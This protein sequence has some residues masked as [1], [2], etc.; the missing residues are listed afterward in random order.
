M[1]QQVE[2]TVKSASGGDAGK[3]D[4]DLSVFDKCRRKTLLK[5]AVVEVVQ[6]D[7]F[8]PLHVRAASSVRLVG[9]DEEFPADG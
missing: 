4:V 8:G 3:V 1:S 6:A 9:D 7:E 2:L 5:E